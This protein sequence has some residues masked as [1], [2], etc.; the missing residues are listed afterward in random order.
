MPTFICVTCG[1]QYAESTEPPEHCAICE[2]ERQYVG[3]SGQ[4]W[5][6]LDELSVTHRN[7]FTDMEEGL[8]RV[9]TVPHFGIG[10]HA[11]LL[12]SPSGNVLWDCISLV[13]YPT[14][15][16][17]QNHGG[18][19]AI[20]LSH[21]HYYS[22]IVEWSRAFGDVPI[23]MHEADREWVMRPDPAIVFW[24]GSSRPLWD[25]ITLI[26]GGG[27]FAGGAMLHW[28]AGAEGKGVLLPGD[29]I[30][31]VHDRNWVCWMYSFV[32]YLPL[33][34][35]DVR[36]VVAAVEPYEFERIYSPWNERVVMCDGKEVVRR[37]AERYVAALGG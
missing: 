11:Y 1:V 10:Q 19:R 35:S 30:Q 31:V 29:I 17:V 27:H 23:Y 4:Q 36:R 7:R 12:Q 14:I 6:T 32:N 16:E 5:T 21:P 18:I 24:D 2:D 25:G 9:G 28:P 33:P 34:P 20:A 8:I 26:H 37:S 15:E 3:W 22:A 13:D